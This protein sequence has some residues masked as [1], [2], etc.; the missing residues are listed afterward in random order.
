MIK[1]RFLSSFVLIFFLCTQIY[2]QNKEAR[3]LRFPTSSKDKLVFSYAGDL[4][5]VSNQGGLARRLTS[6]SEGYEMF[7]HFSPDGSKIAFTA[8]YDGNTEVYIMPSE[9][10]APQRLTYTSTLSRDMVSDRM[11]PNNIVMGWKGNDSIIFR[12]RMNSFNAFKGKLY[13][14]GING[15][16]PYEMPLA[17]G[18]FCS[19]NEDGSMLAFNR[20]FREFRTWKY[21]QGGMADDVWL[22]DRKSKEV[23]KITDN[24]HQNIFPMWHKDKIYFISDRDRTMNLF[25]YDITSKETTKITDYTDYDIKFPSISEYG[26]TYENGGYLYI[27]SFDDRSSKKIDIQILDDVDGG[28]MPFKK[29]ADYMSCYDL[30]PDGK[31]LAVC[32]RGNMFSVPS[33]EGVTYTLSNNSAVHDRTVKW[34]PDGKWIAFISDRSGENEIYVM[35]QN[36][37]EEPIQLTSN[38]DTYLYTIEWSP[39]SKMLLFNDKKGNLKY[40]NV[41]QKKTETVYNS[42]ASEVWNF[43]WAPDS[44]WIAYSVPR[45]KGLSWIEVYNIDSKKAEVVT[46]KLYDSD[47]PSFD[48]EGKYLFFSSNRSF[49]PTYSWTEWNTAY[50][51]MTR[52][53]FVTLSKD[54]PNPFALKNDQVK[55]TAQQP[56]KSRKDKKKDKAK[57]DDKGVKIDFDGIADRINVIPG[58]AGSYGNVTAL[59]D[60]VYYGFY[61]TKSGKVSLNLF[62]L[63]Q[64][65][66]TVLGDYTLYKI[67]ADH[68][69][70]F[71]YGKKTLI[72]LPQGPINLK[73]GDLVDFSG[74]E[75]TID[76]DKEYQQI[77]MESWRVFRDYFYAPNLHGVDWNAMK[78]KY[79]SL[80]KYAKNR[81][82]LNYIIGEMIG[83]A[84]VGHAYVN[85]GD[86]LKPK[87]IMM[88]LL[89]AEVEKDQSGYFKVSKILPGENWTKTARSPLTETGVKIRKGDY[90]TSLNGKSLKDVDNIYTLLIDKVNKQIEL[91]VNSKP[92]EKGSHTVLL[93][94]IANQSSLYYYKWVSGNIKKVS[95]ATNGTVG[96]LHVPDMSTNGLNEFVKLFYPQ[97]DKM[98]LII[99]DRGNGGGNVSPMIIERLGRRL[100]MVTKQRDFEGTVKPFQMLNGP[101]VMLI[102]NYSASDG[103]L[104]PYQFKKLKLGTVI[105]QRS[106]GGVVGI[107]GSRPFVDRADLRVPEFGPYDD[108]G[109]KWIIEGY[110]VD[111]DIEVINDPYKEYMGEDA[112]LNMAIKVV[113]EQL[114]T[115]KP[116]PENPPY[117]VKTK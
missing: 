98:A 116:I 85:G 34:S 94:P 7:A 73:G 25:M 42:K 66:N 44:K 21:Y 86:I 76:L 61:S 18:G 33:K 63:K 114:K 83:E 81:H 64:K 96:Y 32:A 6:D 28:R 31:R 52:L 87:R 13:L 113:M 107:R 14:V 62:D 112:Q 59:G 78:D 29:L 51:D 69:K 19:F 17:T 65:K 109:K 23:S 88:G 53:Y 45:N 82:D 108:E 3:L 79:Q 110:G 90:I 97:L 70:M 102:D 2:A 26:I 92:V 60:K 39:D 91:C 37:K 71:L 56:K 22:F 43:S 49:N 68:K 80:V 47:S 89:G 54:T 104:F 46:S 5:T 36:G 55:Q 99:D 8:Q 58:S 115:R 15:G 27:Y 9:G 101:M 40:V 75:T 106:W 93:K 1:F 50:T 10:G 30:S 72:N 105:G 57:D 38:T 117:P 16:I 4:Y 12:S 48:S 84:N 95:E 67:S 24:V 20:V 103:D 41:E 74:V 111:P 77:F 11:G 100:A 35:N